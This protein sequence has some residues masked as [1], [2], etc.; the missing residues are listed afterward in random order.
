MPAP[1]IDVDG[2]L[3]SAEQIGQPR[4]VGDDV[5]QV[6]LRLPMSTLVERVRAAGMAGGLRKDQ[7]ERFARLW[8]GRS[9]QGSGQAIPANRVASVVMTLQPAAWQD[10][11]GD[12]RI[13][14]ANRA[15]QDASQTIVSESAAIPVGDRQTA[16]DYFASPDARNRLATWADT[17]PATRV[18]LSDQRELQMNV[19]LD[20]QSLGEVLRSQ[21]SPS[22]TSQSDKTQSIDARI[23][24]LP[25]VV[26]GRASV[27]SPR[28]G[29]PRAA[30]SFRSIPS[31]AN[32]T[33]TAEGKSPASGGLLHTARRAESMARE[34]LHAKLIALPLNDGTVIAQSKDAAVQSAIQAAVERARVYQTDYNPDGSAAVRITLDG[35]ELVDQLA[36]PR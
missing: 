33:F 21:L 4:W 27:A 6:A 23:A 5:V 35:G 7:L 22:I 1:G 16:A 10:V 3:N 25:E 32:D 9:L 26:V 14:A 24:A 30:V 13:D 12:A 18:V 15:R 29:P 31:W 20:K 8:D 11:S 28:V 36:R 34:T 17:M 19:Y 2:L